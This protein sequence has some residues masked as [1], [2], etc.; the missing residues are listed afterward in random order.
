MNISRLFWVLCLLVCGPAVSGGRGEELRTNVLQSVAK[1]L[2]ALLEHYRQLHRH[3]ELSFQE[4]KTARYLADQLEQAGFEVTRKVGGHGV[5][6]VRRQGLGP[7]VLVRSDMDALPVKEQTGLSFASTVRATDDCGQEV[8]V[9]HACGHD[10]NMTCLIGTARVLMQFKDRWSGTLVLIGQPAEERGGGAKAMLDD[11]LFTRFPR[12]DYCL[13]LHANADMPAGSIGYAA[14]YAMA[15]V[16][17]VDLTIRGIGGHGAYPHATKD[18]IVL[19]AQTILALQTIVS[20][21]IPPTEPAVITVGSI[22]GGTKH[23]V[24]P[25]EVRL[26]ITLR[27][28]SDQVRQ[29]LIEAIRRVSRGLAQAAGLPEERWPIVVVQDEYTPATYNDPELTRRLATVFQAWFGKANVLPRPPTM[30]GEDFSRYGRTEPKIPICMFS[31]GGV[32]PERIKEAGETG[33][34]LPSLHSSLFAPDAEVAIRTGV[35]AMTA[36]VL[37]LLAQAGEVTQPEG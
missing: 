37:D 27:S 7:T 2:P 21:E 32:P 19:A 23:N 34:S 15:N 9:M 18:P 20:R 29:Q 11:G 10:L 12:P 17:A 24:I 25:E 14:G 3:P 35:T 8:P 31:V 5:V 30:G 4:E 6:A 28:Y 1:D 26:Q 16:D 36:A 13:A 33:H 22:H